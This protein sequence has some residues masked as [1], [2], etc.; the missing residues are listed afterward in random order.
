MSWIEEI[1]KKATGRYIPFS[2]VIAEEL[3][4]ELSEA[5]KDA[6]K[7]RQLRTITFEVSDLE[8]DGVKEVASHSGEGKIRELLLVFSSTGARIHLF[9]DGFD[10]IPSHRDLSDLISL[11]PKLA[12][13]SAFQDEEGNYVVHVRDVSF[14][15]GFSAV[16][17]P[18]GGSKL[19][20]AFAVVDALLTQ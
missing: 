20:R 3:A 2:V 8:V 19:K 1:L 18:A 10:R 7:P 14:L 5:I 6:V 13:L 9:V 11:S 4:A 16:V 15:N 17:S 12:Y